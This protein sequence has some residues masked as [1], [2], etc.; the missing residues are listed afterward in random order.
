MKFL[1]F[2]PII[3]FFAFF[4]LLVLG[5]LIFVFKLV[6]KGKD[7][8]WIGKLVDKKYAEKDKEDSNLKE[9]FYTL[10]FET[11]EGKTVKVGTSLKV[12]NE[13]K[14]GDRAEKKKGELWPKKLS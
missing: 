12:Y 1:F 3:G 6:K 7:S 5:F 11:K 10:V 13:Y 4:G 2:L 8:A 14:I 9:H